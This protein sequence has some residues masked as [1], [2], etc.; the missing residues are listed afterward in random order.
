MKKII[1][2]LLFLT[3]ASNTFSQ[4]TVK[5]KPLKLKYTAPPRWVAEEFGAKLNWE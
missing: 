1:A 3:I 2:C 5:S 4:E